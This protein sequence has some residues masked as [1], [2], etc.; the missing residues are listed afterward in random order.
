[1]KAHKLTERGKKARRGL[2]AALL[3]AEM[4]FAPFTAVFTPVTAL[5]EGEP[6]ANASNSITIT[7]QSYNAN[8]QYL[9]IRVFNA[10]VEGG[11]SQNDTKDYATNIQWSNAA[12]KS[13]VTS[14][15]AEYKS[16]L[17]QNEQTSDYHEWLNGGDANNAQ[18]A[19]EFISTHIQDEAYSPKDT[20][21]GTIAYTIDSVRSGGDLFS[22]TGDSFATGLAQALY[23]CYK[24]STG[25]DSTAEDYSTMNSLASKPVG[26]GAESVDPVATLVA[27][28]AANLKQG[29]YLIVT[30]PDSMEPG[31][32]ATA[33]IW[34][35]AGGHA[36]VITEKTADA[37]A[38]LE[39]LDDSMIYDSTQIKL[40]S[41]GGVPGRTTTYADAWTTTADANTGQDLWYRMTATLP[42]NFASYGNYPMSFTITLPTGMELAYTGE[43]GNKN[44]GAGV[45]LKAYQDQTAFNGVNQTETFAPGGGTTDATL[46]GTSGSGVSVATGDS[47]TT[48]TVAVT[49]IKTTQFQES[50]I[51]NEGIVA[52][53]FKAH[54]KPNA[55]YGKGSD[56]LGNQMTGAY[57]Y[58]A[59]PADGDAATSVNTTTKSVSTYAYQLDLAKH[60]KS[61]GATLQGAKFM[62]Q[63]LPGLDAT[64]VGGT[65]IG[66]NPDTASAGKFVKANGELVD[67]PAIST[68]TDPL[69]AYDRLDTDAART[70]FLT[71]YSDYIFT[72]DS[73][74]GKLPIISGLD[75]GIYKIQELVVPTGPAGSLQP[76]EGGKYQRQDS[77]IYLTISRTFSEVSGVQQLTAITAETRGGETASVSDQLMKARIGSYTSEG[78]GNKHYYIS[79][80]GAGAAGTAVCA[81]INGDSPTTADPGQKSTYIIN[82][83]QGIIHMMAV[84]ERALTMPITGMTG[85]QLIIVL[86]GGMIAVSLACGVLLR[87]RRRKSTDKR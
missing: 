32:Y 45:M 19:L 84:D 72:T 11:A 6:A 36:K 46:T 37:T 12:V 25:V 69:A 35:T 27:G 87:G 86:G 78:T 44:Y 15:L 38:K 48:L 52:L 30:N 31:E 41:S 8:Q 57:T 64:T 40:P 29:F 17:R 75:E 76:S 47:G 67:L 23:H 39:V 66:P 82:E 28:T 79:E 2:I 22:K 9:G 83:T 53:Y 14:Y 60:D 49:N 5:A 20:G 85:Q 13:A 61:N 42:Q 18:N 24:T 3:A 74:T 73:S 56:G 16:A 71:D 4:A 65:S 51:T 77:D 80:G 7:A 68:S 26:G 54:L 81:G 59:N 50:Y 62:I 43:G 21:L 63:V 55:L 1:M 58:P 10:N 34:V 70:Q 33:P